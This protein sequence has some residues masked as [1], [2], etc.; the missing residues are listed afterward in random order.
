MLGAENRPLLLER[1]KLRETLAQE[2]LPGERRAEL[3][4]RMEA[5]LA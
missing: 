5:L 1:D 3:A 2:G 4:K